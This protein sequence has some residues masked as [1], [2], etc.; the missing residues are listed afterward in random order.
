LLLRGIVWLLVLTALARPEWLETPIERSI[1]T[2]DLLL[3]VDL[4]GSM[5][6]EDFTNAAGQSVDRLTD[7]KEVLGDFLARREGDRVGLVV[8]GSAPFL[9]VPFTTELP[10]SFHSLRMHGACCGP[11]VRRCRLPRLPHGCESTR[12][13]LNWRRLSHELPRRELLDAMTIGPMVHPS[14]SAAGQSGIRSYFPRGAGLLAAWLLAIVAVAGP[15]WRPVPSPFADEPVPVMVVL[16]AGETMNQSDLMPSRMERARL[17]VADFTAERKEQP[18]GLVAYAGTAHLVLPPTRDTSV[19]ATMAAEISPEIMPKQGD[20][21][22]GA[23]QLAVNTLGDSGGSIVVFTDTA[24]E[25]ENSAIANFHTKNHLPVYFLAIARDDTPEYD[26]IRHV[27]SALKAEV[28]RMTPDTQ[29]V[30]ALARLAGRAPVAIGVAG[31]GTRWAE[32]GWWLVPLIA[33]LSLISF[34]RVRDIEP[35]EAAG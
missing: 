2:R 25:G 11:D 21:L 15:T 33:L 32:A 22:A 4:S 9:Q 12:G 8:F 29:D 23:L 30:R 14:A 7:A 35:R 10:C 17:K 34:G 6:H 13:R 24:A 28:S 27:A 5:E 20:N 16:K 31:E 19:V 18:L 26:A 3:L 1:P